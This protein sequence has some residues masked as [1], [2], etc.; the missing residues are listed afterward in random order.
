MW[1]QGINGRS[2]KEGPLVLVLVAM[3]SAYSV[4]G[5]NRVSSSPNSW[6]L[7]LGR[8]EARRG[9]SRL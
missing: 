2:K 4:Y 9:L 3:D 5:G 7:S 1:L 8:N 6:S